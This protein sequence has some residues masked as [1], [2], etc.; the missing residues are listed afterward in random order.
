[1]FRAILLITFICSWSTALAVNYL[2]NNGKSDYTIILSVDASTTEQNAAKEFKEYLDQYVIGQDDAKKT[3]SV[4][5]YNHYKRI[6]CDEIIDDV[7]IQKSNIFS[8]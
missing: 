7:E 8:L 3:L 4:A 2:F 1:M 5:V 6:A